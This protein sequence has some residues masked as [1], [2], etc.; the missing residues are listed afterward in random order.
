MIRQEGGIRW[1]KNIILY[2][3]EGYAYKFKV[4][5]W[6]SYKEFLVAF[7]D[8]AQKCPRCSTCGR[9][10][11]SGQAVGKNRDKLMCLTF[12]C[13]FSAAF[14][15]GHISKMENLYVPLNVKRFW[16]YHLECVRQECRI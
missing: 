6:E 15:A 5:H 4:K 10:L 8:V 12:D 2:K 13:C 14:F 3:H 9:I 1:Q 16:Q 7:K 11:F